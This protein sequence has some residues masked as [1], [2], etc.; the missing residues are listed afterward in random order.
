M[1]DPGGLVRC[2]ELANN[3]LPLG[4]LLSSMY[5]MLQRWPS[6]SAK[7]QPYIQPSFSSGPRCIEPPAFFTLTAQRA[8]DAAA[9]AGEAHRISA[10]VLSHADPERHT[11]RIAS[12]ECPSSRSSSAS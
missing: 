5:K 11:S 1:C 3:Q 12:A 10:Q 4:F 2:R 6:G 9:E 7:P 8:H